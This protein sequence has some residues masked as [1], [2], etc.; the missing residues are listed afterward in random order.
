VSISA[1]FI[2]GQPSRHDSAICAESPGASYKGRVFK[3]LKSAHLLALWALFHI[4][5]LQS[6][7]RLVNVLKQWI[8]GRLCLNKISDS[9]V[10]GANRILANIEPIDPYE[11]ISVAL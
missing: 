11:F 9:F 7:N 10:K 4:S 6:L 3:L 2:L 5:L 8:L 1:H